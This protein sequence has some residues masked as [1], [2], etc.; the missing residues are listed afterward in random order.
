MEMKKI[1]GYILSFGK[2]SQSAYLYI[3]CLVILFFNGI[4]F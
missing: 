2:N 4:F 3:G 1:E